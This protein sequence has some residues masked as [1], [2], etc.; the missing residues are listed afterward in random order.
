MRLGFGH[1]PNKGTI[2]SIENA[3]SGGRLRLYY[4][5]KVDYALGEVVGVE[6]LIRW[7]H[8][9]LG[10][11]APAEFLPLIE[12]DDLIIR[13]GD[14]VIDTVMKQLDAWQRMGIDLQVS[15]N[16]SR[17]Q[18][19][20]GGFDK[21]LEQLLVFCRTPLSERSLFLWCFRASSIA[22]GSFSCRET[23]AFCWFCFLLPRR[24]NQQQLQRKS[25]SLQG[26]PMAPQPA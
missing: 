9:V 5:P 8:P 12:N 21:R 13:V 24:C 1:S 23:K 20:H 22:S 16:I 25:G 17:Y 15:L 14:W 2:E 11:R 3:L 7:N 26:L 18:F 4:Q 19:L 6:A 10:I